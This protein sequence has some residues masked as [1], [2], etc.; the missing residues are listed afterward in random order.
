[1]KIAENKNPSE[2][3]EHF[4]DKKDDDSDDEEEEE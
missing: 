3:R 2:N 4:E 1:M